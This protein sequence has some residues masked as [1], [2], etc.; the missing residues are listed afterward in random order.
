V[1]ETLEALEDWEIQTRTG[2]DRQEIETLHRKLL[3]E[4]KK[5]ELREAEGR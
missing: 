2:A 5:S 4:M 3:E 1:L